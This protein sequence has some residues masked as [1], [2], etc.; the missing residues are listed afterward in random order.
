MGVLFD[1]TEFER[2]FKQ[3]E[4][5]L[6]SAEND[7]AGGF[8]N[9]VCFKAEQAAQFAVKGLLRALG[10][11]AFGHALTKLLSDLSK[12]GVPVP[13]D[14]Q[15]AGKILES[16]YIPSLCV[17][18]YPSG[19]PYEFYDAQRAENSL[20]A[21]RKILKFVEEVVR[22]CRKYSHAGRSHPSD[23]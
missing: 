5:T 13:E 11:P 17:D 4:Q 15:K 10:E 2:W 14:I 1:N 9:W 8:W 3:A 12:I 16:E 23:R 19:S 7:A 20:Q 21:C 6:K 22:K 18:A